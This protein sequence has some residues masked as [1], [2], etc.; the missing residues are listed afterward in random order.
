MQKACFEVSPFPHL[1]LRTAI[2]CVRKQNCITWCN[3][4]AQTP[5]FC[6][7]PWARRACTAGTMT[8]HVLQ[9]AGRRHGKESGTWLV[10]GG[11][12]ALGLLTTDYLLGHGVTD[13]LLLSRSGRH[14]L[15]LTLQTNCAADSPSLFNAVGLLCLLPVCV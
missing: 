1:T 9:Y 14:V 11:L 4:V 12:G 6:I 3:R 8:W 5:H 13:V 15:L 7:L 10:T 2:S